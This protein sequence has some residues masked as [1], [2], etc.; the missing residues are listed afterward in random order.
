VPDDAGRLGRR[1][2]YRLALPDAAPPAPGRASDVASDP[3]LV[4]SEAAGLAPSEVRR[5]LAG[6]QVAIVGLEGP[7][8]HAAAIL[9]RCGIGGLLLI[10][11]Y[12]CEAGNLPLLPPLGPGA[13]GLPRERALQQALERVDAGTRLEASGLA[14]L[15]RADLHAAAGDS[16]LLIGCFDEDFVATHHWL[17]G[18]SLRLGKP[19]VYARIGSGSAIIGPLVVPTRTACYLCWRMR[20]VA[21]AADF[22]AA[23]AHEEALARRR[24]PALHER[25]IS[26]E[27]SARAGAV[28]A[29]EVL[30]HLLPVGWP[31]LEGK[32][33]EVDGPWLQATL[34]GVLPVPECPSCGT[35][36]RTRPQPSLAELSLSNLSRARGNLLSA[37]PWLVSRACGVVTSLD[38]VRLAGTGAPAELRLATAELGNYR[39]LDQVPAT[40][41]V[42]VGKGLTRA[43]A[44]RGALGEAVERYSG[45][46][47]DPGGVVNAR[48]D[49]LDGPS[50]DPRSLVLYRPEQY[51]KLPYAPYDETT[52]LGWVAARSLVTGAEVL[53]P[54]IA[55][56]LG[57]HA[58]SFEELLCPT[59]SN[60]LAA[61][62][63]LADAVLAAACE[64]FERDAFLVTWMNRLPAGRVDPNRH[65][66]RRFARVCRAYAWRGVEIQL[67]RLASDHPCHVFLALAIQRAGDGGPAAVVGLG[68]HL[69]PGLAAWR[70]VLEVA[71]ARAGGGA[72]PPQA[73]ARMDE[74][75]ADPQSVAT[76][77]DHGLLYADH[78]ALPAFG[79]LERSPA[80]DLDW[81]TPDLR[82]PVTGLRRLAGHLGSQ[83]GDL[84][85]VNCTPPDMAGLGLHTARV[86]VPGFQPLHFGANEPRLAGQR[87]YELPHRLG[88]TPSPT[89]PETLNGD[90][91]PL[92]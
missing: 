17:N 77:H 87:L 37:L 26:A 25:A 10:D 7:G 76:M 19:A 31:T 22:P 88:L 3:L 45:T 1:L 68:G 42:C 69:D 29:Q 48:R 67:Y 85:Y 15:T 58:A 18:T 44:W 24:R 20:A 90:P 71:Q 6:V 60:G 39:L 30:G 59:S 73:R 40:E 84:L 61:G 11:P 75:V 23:M 91:H 4:C 32:I 52:R 72:P 16:Q 33:L 9:T 35:E 57:Y 64:V 27:L 36:R 54:A 50:L 47:R 82:G 63:T 56:F 89:T 34:H 80:V 81:S 92:A 8:G 43:A 78:R 83:G 12:P 21:C 86:L 74:L 46:F 62:E 38:D 28:L 13:L 70:A 49:E 79:F 66:D 2:V 53:V 14:A 65:P 51:P 55:V 41:P 5:R